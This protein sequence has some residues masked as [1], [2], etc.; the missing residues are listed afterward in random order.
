MND[1][2]TRPIAL[3]AYELLADRYAAGI[4]TKAHNA[5]HDRPAVLNLLPSLDGLRVLDAGCG[6]GKYA[7]EMLTRHAAHV[8]SFDVSPAMIAHARTRLQPFIDAGRSEVREGNLLTP[9]D[10]APDAAFDLAIAPLVFDYL[11]DWSLPV[12]EIYRALRPGGLFV[13]SCGHPFSDYLILKSSAYRETEIYAWPWRGFGGEPVL[14]PEYRRPLGAM[15]AP[16]VGAGFVIDAI[17]EPE[18]IEKMRESDP[19]DYEKLMRF[20]AFL[21]I[22]ARKLG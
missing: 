3:E 16:I 12:S 14:V 5:Y 20:P 21:A 2:S 10:F 22:R 15:I 1:D 6:P 19:D 8:L 4:E 7:E 18:P 11:P 13:I 9:L 17:V